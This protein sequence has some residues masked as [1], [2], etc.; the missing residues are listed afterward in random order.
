MPKTK[1]DSV[2]V[3]L[4]IPKALHTAATEEADKKE[5][6]LAKQVIYWARIGQMYCEAT[7]S[8]EMEPVNVNR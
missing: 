4:R 8:G 6:S 2:P 3:T 7:E 1:K 5:R